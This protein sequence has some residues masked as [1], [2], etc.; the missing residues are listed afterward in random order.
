MQYSRNSSLG[1]ICGRSDVNAG[2]PVA[3]GCYD[4]KAANFRM[5]AQRWA[6]GVVGPTTAQARRS[7]LAALS[8]SESTTMG[9]GWSTH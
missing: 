6:V 4:T 5:A 2:H 9:K 3:Y 1:A 7:S 8:A